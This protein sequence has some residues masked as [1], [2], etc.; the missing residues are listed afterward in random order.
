[1]GQIK[2]IKKIK[3][4]AGK[5]GNPLDHTELVGDGIVFVYKVGD[6]TLLHRHS[7]LS[8]GIDEEIIWLKRLLSVEP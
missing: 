7:E 4:L 8:R 6:E 2:D 1:M 3:K 5:F